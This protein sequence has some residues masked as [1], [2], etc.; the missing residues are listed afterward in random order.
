MAPWKLV[1]GGKDEISDVSF[2]QGS[3]GSQP[4]KVMQQSLSRPFSWTLLL[5]PDEILPWSTFQVQAPSPTYTPLFIAL[6]LMVFIL[7]LSSPCSYK[8]P[9]LDLLPWLCPT[10]MTLCSTIVNNTCSAPTMCVRHPTK[11]LNP[12]SHL[13]FSTTSWGK[14]YF[15]IYI[16]SNWG[17]EDN[18]LKVTQLVCDEVPRIEPGSVRLSALGS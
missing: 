14:C 1:S 11:A 4:N 6:L 5:V 15:A 13:I 7:S 2:W 10:E 3:S 17:S 16:W 18:F 9:G 8:D 12:F